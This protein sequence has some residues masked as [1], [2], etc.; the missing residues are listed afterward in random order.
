MLF[1]RS[2]NASVRS[3]LSRS[4]LFTS[5]SRSASSAVFTWGKADSGALGHKNY[6]D[7]TRE[8]RRL[9]KSKRFKD[10]TCGESYSLAIDHDGNMFGWG[11]GPCSFD[12]E[13]P[14]HI[15]VPSN[16]QVV[17]AIAG[18]KHAACIDANGD[19][20]TWGK[21]KGG[22]FSGGGQLGQGDSIKSADSP[23]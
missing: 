20:F 5:S 1:R 6:D 4:L 22:W 11:N 15:P 3:S 21:Q 18:P 23:R 12:S 13:T 17:K 7:I 8:P 9:V 2:F 19:M 14:V 10:I 16:T